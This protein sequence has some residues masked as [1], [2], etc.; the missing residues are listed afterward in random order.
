MDILD[1]LLAHDAWTT[2]AILRRCDALSDEELDRPLGIGPGS[3]RATV[4]HILHNME[5]WTDL[6]AERPVRLDAAAPRTQT[7]PVLLARLSA[8]ADDLALV[9]RRV[10]LEGRLDDT[11]LDALDSPAT[12][13]SFGGA[14]AHVITHSMHHRAQLLFMLRS[15]GLSGLPEGDVLSWEAHHR[16]TAGP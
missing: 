8:A 7:V 9:S 6:I 5:L 13:K 14:I 2:E 12:E 4:I 11:F 3:V 10:L 15:L 1:R 16:R